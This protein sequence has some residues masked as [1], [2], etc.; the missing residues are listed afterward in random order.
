MFCYLVFAFFYKFSGVPLGVYEK[1]REDVCCIALYDSA[2]LLGLETDVALG[3]GFTV[4]RFDWN[5]TSL[6][7]RVVDVVKS[8]LLDCS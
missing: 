7:D 1:I 2:R 4:A 3:L 5:E 6:D 8:F